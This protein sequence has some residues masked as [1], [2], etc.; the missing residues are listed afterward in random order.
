MPLRP[1]RPAHAP[2]RPRLERRRG[3]VALVVALMLLILLGM[4]ALVIDLGYQGASQ[5]E[6]QAAA[7][8]AAHAGAMQLDGT[9]DGLDAATQAAL[10]FAAFNSAAGDPVEL[11][12]SA[13]I[14]LGIWDEVSGSFSAGGATEMIDA[15][16][17]T[18]RRDDLPAWFARAAFGRDSLAASV[19]SVARRTYEGAGRVDCFLPLAVPSCVIEDVYGIDHINQ[20]DLVLNP[21][22]VNN[23]AWARPDAHPSASWLSSQIWNCSY[24]GSIEVIDSVELNNGLIASVLA[25]LADKIEASDTTWDSALWGSL[26]AQAA[27]SGIASSRYGHTL[28]GPIAVFDDDSYCTSP[29][30]MNGTEEITGFVW[31][32]I[33]EV[34]TTGAAA[35]RT[36][37]MRLETTETH[38]LGTGSG[39]PDYGVVYHKLA[40]VR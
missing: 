3:A 13:D 40:L 2:R 22:G 31:G 28:E 35:N 6:L 25:D 15:V 26:P 20:V 24:E 30:P 10:D 17:V 4:A 34:V 7:D 33:Y 36:I 8:A 21:P 5:A 27:R 32:A 38:D 12:P 39:G 11:D 19:Q 1:R 29:G 14:L 37:K 9:E 18:A 23:V 16:Q